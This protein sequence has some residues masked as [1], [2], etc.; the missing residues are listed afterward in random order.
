[1]TIGKR[2]VISFAAMLALI[3]GLSYTFL[4]TMDSVGGE[5]D[6][7]ITSTATTLDLVQG[8]AKGFYEMQAASRGAQLSL[9]NNDGQ[10]LA[11]YTQKFDAAYLQVQGQAEALRP[12]LVTDQSREGLRQIEDGLSAWTLLHAQYLDL[13]R[14]KDFAQA[15]RVM[16]D[17]IAPVFQS[18]QQS[19]A[20]QVQD[21]RGLQTAANQEAKASISWS[22][23]V[24]L[25]LIGVS[26]AVG[27]IVILTVRGI[28]A[29]LRRL[30]VEMS[31]GADQVASASSQVSVAS[32]SLAQASSEQAAS[33]EETSASSEE[34]ASMTRKNAENAQAAARLTAEVD[35]RVGE[36]NHSLKEM[37][38]SMKDINAASDKISRIIKVIDEIA[39]QTNILA[40]NA[41]VEAA[42]AGEAGLGFAVVAD[43]VRTLAQRSAQAAKDTAA[44][45]EESISKSN[46]GSAKLSQVAEAISAITESVAKVKTLMDE[47]NLGSQEQARGMQQIS[48]AIMQME[49]VT[50]KTAA[51]S[52]ESASASEQ[53]NSQAATMRGV[54]MKLRAMVDAAAEAD[55]SHAPP[56]G[57]GTQPASQSTTA[58]GTG[59]TPPGN[60]SSGLAALGGAICSQQRADNLKDDRAAAAHPAK[61]ARE[62]FPLDQDFK[63]F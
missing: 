28:G 17:K 1:M 57:A 24:A 2:L 27:V 56:A 53:L 50:Q 26:L 55:A 11:T 37:I 32:Q 45:I 49:Q 21:Q 10:S 58:A 29:S 41:A 39:F 59:R 3:L 9:V 36:A 20:A 30:T 35:R 46:E 25:A 14:K 62:S 34:I 16:I 42:R 4:T 18:I 8:L 52:E 13:G 7:A 22:R 12:L 63:E 61:T 38:T 23:W 60:V 40:L 19:V 5:L 47:V 15:H 48:Q 6:K 44:M 51:N 54:V 33:L 43:E 31:N